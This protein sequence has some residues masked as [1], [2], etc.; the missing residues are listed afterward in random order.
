[1]GAAQ[2][3]EKVVEAVAAPEAPIFAVAPG[4]SENQQRIRARMANKSRATNQQHVAGAVAAPRAAAEPKIAPSPP[5]LVQPS[6]S[7][8]ALGASSSRSQP[9]NCV[10]ATPT[11][12]AK[13]P[14]RSA[15]ERA[16]GVR[17]RAI[18]YDDNL[19]N[20]AGSDPRGKIPAI[21]NVHCREPLTVAQLRAA[22]S[23]CQQRAAD[24]DADSLEVVSFYDFDGTLSLQDGLE[25][26][27]GATFEQILS[28]LFGDAER[29]QVLRALLSSLLR[30][31]R[32]YILTA[33]PG[34]VLIARVLNQLLMQGAQDAMH[35]APGGGGGASSGRGGSNTS[36]P[37][38]FVVDHTVRYIRSGEK[39]RAIQK[40]LRS[41][42]FNLV[43]T[44]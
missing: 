42:G 12:A 15:T 43:T 14:A 33:N 6:V 18:F 3:A 7:P 1:M 40:I 10:R 2:S 44:Y 22:L 17:A 28:T 19:L 32:C 39:I 5:S 4:L 16:R 9:K 31:E 37:Q 23:D 20:F 13:S 38:Q 25:V 29:Q 27:E 30:A 26:P 41:R 36:R 11:S 24:T 35:D 21:S 8:T 34:Y